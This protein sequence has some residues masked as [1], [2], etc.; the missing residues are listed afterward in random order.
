MSERGDTAAVGGGSTK[1]KEEI[2]AGT[3]KD[4]HS[5]G[6]ADTPNRHLLHAHQL[7]LRHPT[8]QSEQVFEAPIPPTFT[9]WLLS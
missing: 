9:R 1:N 3:A 5:T 4:S 2:M 6:Q 8:L 7:R